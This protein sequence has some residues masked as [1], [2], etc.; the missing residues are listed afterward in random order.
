[1][2]FAQ[3]E[4]VPG[5]TLKN[6]ALIALAVLGAGYYIK[7]IFFGSKMPQPLE[8]KKAADYVHKNE[9][10]N[11]VAENREE[12]KAIFSKIGGVER[13]A[14]ATLDTK[15]QHISDEITEQGKDI[16]GLKKET[17]M[18]NQSI[19]AIQADIKILLQRRV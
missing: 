12:H 14:S 16:A 11:H 5:E 19:A 1:M 17:E 4:P 6:F 7:E 18:Q 15:I 9:F 10:E 3:L 8:T 2:M 13:G